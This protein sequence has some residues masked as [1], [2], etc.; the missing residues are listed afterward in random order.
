LTCEN[1]GFTSKVAASM[2]VNVG[3]HLWSTKVTFL[4]Q[5]S[6]AQRMFPQLGNLWFTLVLG[7]QRIGIPN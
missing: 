7:I 5:S 2:R 4:Y 6:A 3:V 1:V